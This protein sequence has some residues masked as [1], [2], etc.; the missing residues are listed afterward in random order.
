MTNMERRLHKMLSLHEGRVD[1]PYKDSLGLWTAGVGH[2]IDRR[3]GGSLHPSWKAFPLTDVEI[4]EA[5]TDDIRKHARELLNAQPWVTKLDDCRQAVLFDMCFNLGIEPFDGDGF[6]DWPMFVSQM[7]AGQWVA[8]AANM[9]STLWAKQVGSRAIRLA[10]MVE[11]G[12]WP[13]E[14]I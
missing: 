11:T 4:D 9:R 10:M 1:V 6:K 3:R 14:F 2:L 5:L 12:A 8:A 7:K 13:P